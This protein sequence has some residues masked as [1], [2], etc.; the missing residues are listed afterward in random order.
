VVV[1]GNQLT[2]EL[3]ALAEGSYTFSLAA[4]SL[5]DTDGQSLSEPFS[6]TFSVDQTAPEVT[7]S[8][9]T[10]G[11]VVTS[12]D[13]SVT[14]QFSEPLA[15]STLAASDVLLVGA[16]SGPLVP[17]T[18]HYEN[19]TLTLSYTALAEDS[20]T[21]TLASGDGAF[22]DLAGND[23]AGGDYVVEFTVDLLNP[24]PLAVSRVAPLGSLVY[25]GRTSGLINKAGDSDR[26]SFPVLVGDT[27]AFVVTPTDPLAILTVELEGA[28]G[29]IT[30]SG[31]GRPIVLPPSTMNAAGTQVVRIKGD[32]VTQYTLKVVLNAAVEEYLTIAR[33]GSSLN[34]DSSKL[35][36]GAS[37]RVAAIGHSEPTT[38]SVGAPTVEPND[39]FAKAVFS[40]IG[41]GTGINR[42]ASNGTIGDNPAFA[43]GLDVDILAM[44]LDV[45]ER[46]AI[47]I[48]ASTIGSTLDS[49]LTLFDSSGRI[50]AVNDDSNSSDSFIDFTPAARDTYYVGISG[51]ANQQYDPFIPGSGFAGSTGTYE[52]GIERQG[53]PATGTSPVDLSLPDVDAFTFDLTGFVGKSI[54]VLL[55]ALDGAD[56]SGSA[57]QLIG[58]NSST[59]LA[60]ASASPLGAP[61]ANIDFAILNFV[62]PS[63]GVYTARLTSAALG[64]YVVV[65]TE[66]LQFVVEPNDL[67]SDPL[68]E[69]SG[70]IRTL[71]FLAGPPGTDPGP[72]DP[73]SGSGTSSS[74]VE[75]ESNN[76]PGTANFMPLGFDADE[77]AQLDVSGTLTTTD[78]DYF[79]VT[80]N[81]GDILQ[82][83][84]T[85]ASRVT[86]FDAANVE[87][88][89]SSQNRTSV[90]PQSSPLRVTGG[91]V[92][93][94][95]VS[96]T[97]DYFVRASAGQGAYTLDFNLVRPSFESKFLGEHQ[98]IFLD[99]DGATFDRAIFGV[100]GMATLSPLADFL[101]AWGLSASDL[102]AVIDAIIASVT[103][104]ISAD[105]RILGRNGDF[106]ATGIAGQFDVEILNSRN[107]IDPFG[108][109]NVSRIIIGGTQEQLGINT[110]GFAQSIDPG[111]FDAEETAV[112]LLDRLS[113]DDEAATSLNHYTL[114]P[115]VSIVDLIGVAVGNIVA[116]E[117]AH[118]LGAFHTEPFNSTVTLIDQGGS[119]ANFLGLVG[120]VWGDGDEADVDFIPD[121]FVPIEGF[122]GREDPM[123]IIAFGLSTGTVDPLLIGPRVHSI[124]PAAVLSGSPV[125][126]IN[127]MFNE[128]VTSATATDPANYR[129]VD[130]GI[131]GVFEDGAG[132]DSV[133]AVIPSFD[134]IATV[135]LAID[136]GVGPL[137]FGRF[138]LTL[139]NDE[140]SVEDL[141]GNPLNSVTGENGGSATVHNF[142]VLVLESGG[143]LYRFHVA[144][145][146]SAT[147][148]TATP[149]YDSAP[150][151]RNS[152]DPMVVVYDESGNPLAV[153]RSSR[154]GRNALLVFNPPASGTYI[155][156]VRAQSGIGEY[157]LEFTGV[158]LPGDFNRDGAVDTA[159][160]VTWRKTQGINVLPHAG[161][162]GNGDGVIDGDDHTVWRANFGSVG[163]GQGAGNER[164]GEE[165]PAGGHVHFNTDTWLPYS[166][167]PR[168]LA[169]TPS[170]SSTATTV[171]ADPPT[172]AAFAAA[173][174]S[175]DF[176]DW[177]ANDAPKRSINPISTAR[178]LESFELVRIE[179]LARTNAVLIADELNGD[180]SNDAGDRSDSAR[181]S[182]RFSL[183]RS[184]I[185]ELTSGFNS[186]ESH[187][188]FEC[189]AKSHS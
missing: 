10:S 15:V 117:V 158:I 129:L 115:D 91:T 145:N 138:R 183:R 139:G 134:G 141:D 95:V 140:T 143:D 188:A 101:P 132:D 163:A 165:P 157:S 187:P 14:I 110:V 160:F 155:V 7:S 153:D 54:D 50:V 111:N 185:D 22:E 46:V 26:Y 52:I 23:L 31:P 77:L 128:P 81:P 5:A 154:D 166:A 25:A 170:A 63:S 174:E 21:L 92:A 72:P 47:D 103:E 127:I 105:P 184:A 88:I 8:S 70:D 90:Y 149:F 171:T 104:N 93:T 83:S 9:L 108:D 118:Y 37:A 11:Q 32:R 131:N 27:A 99:F 137:T 41:L 109:A 136:A 73:E 78:S 94:Y 12:G 80:L 189:L 2:F 116:H 66:R 18:F 133:I 61:T 156:Q 20:Y 102:N 186:L 98:R 53:P 68:R 150:G 178:T 121:F 79:R 144:V 147:F 48:N 97:G 40:G 33:T 148:A 69:L 29:S 114:D 57:L 60:T 113:S 38:L 106:A 181:N 19:Q 45:G 35:N 58:P 119:F 3:P 13:L 85:G 75:T 173:F 67:P 17:A 175:L 179:D 87:L 180:E 168:P 30:T 39:T 151:A 169:S 162:D 122:S 59:V 159:D 4:G 84:L 34:I 62:V 120:E 177:L 76:S 43:A 124:D 64:D 82:V 86:I 123:N 42:Y 161:A 44:Q 182:S 130:F 176:L 142:E 49:F 55:T 51:F 172:D 65:V 16:V 167:A 126:V 89:G 56:L 107:H 96:E 6:T 146:N 36:I 24:V 1:D 164:G 125:S 71:G 100:A 152:L 28:N 112:V 135:Q 74:F